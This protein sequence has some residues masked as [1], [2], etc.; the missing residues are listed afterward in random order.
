[1]QYFN[2]KKA[3]AHQDHH[4]KS[5]APVIS[6][7]DEAFLNRI[8]SEG[9]PP[10]LPSR[11]TM[12][13]A[14]DP[15]GNDMQIALKEEAAHTPLPEEPE[16]EHTSPH[17]E[18]EKGAEKGKGKAKKTTRWSFLRR[19]SRDRSTKVRCTVISVKISAELC[20]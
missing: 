1:M 8:A 3:K 20:S 12:L 9:T 17:D 2:Y 5:E 14:G 10:P 13:T 18:T 6:E 11:P 7:E 4:E 16:A 15:T 19:D